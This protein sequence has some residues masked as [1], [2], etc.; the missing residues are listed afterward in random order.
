LVFVAMA[1]VTAALVVGL[2]VAIY[3]LFKEGKALE[4][5]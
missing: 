1:A 4:G 5:R 3:A 2:S